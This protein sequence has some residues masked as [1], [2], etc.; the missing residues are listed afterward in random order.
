MPVQKRQKLILKRSASMMLLLSV[1]IFCDLLQMGMADAERGVA[2]L[3]FK[4]LEKGE[5]FAQP[6][7][8]PAFDELHRL[9]ERNS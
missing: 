5:F 9:A 3:P 6:L 7:G 2:L 1:N 8:G 4:R